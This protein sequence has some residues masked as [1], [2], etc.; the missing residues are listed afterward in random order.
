MHYLIYVSSAVKLFSEDDLFFLLEQA[1]I[2]NTKYD[3]TGML[4]YIDGNFMQCLEGKKN[5]VE[6][7]YTKI[8]EDGR[9]KDLTEIVFDPLKERNFK[10]WSMGFK[11]CD[12][13]ML[14]QSSGL[15]DLS[16]DTFRKP[17][18]NTCKHIAL[19]VLRSFYTQSGGENPVQRDVAII[20]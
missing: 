19:D 1:R 17:P 18:F 8:R 13:A 20:S 14:S 4:L 2:N 16:V 15:A 7:I 6:I 10:G 11:A 5:H 3:V 12:E 9:H